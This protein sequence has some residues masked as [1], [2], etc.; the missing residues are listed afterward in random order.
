MSSLL[1][2]AAEFK[3]DNT[4]ISPNTTSGNK[5]RTS[6]LNKA[7]RSAIASSSPTSSLNSSGFIPEYDSNTSNKTPVQLTH[8]SIDQYQKQTDAHTAHITKLLDS[9][10]KLNA[11]N[12]AHGLA[13]YT[14][15]SKKPIRTY[16][17]V[18]P[19]INNQPIAPVDPVSVEP[20][21]LLPSPGVAI[22]HSQGNTAPI[23]Y[24]PSNG[25]SLG[26]HYLNQGSPYTQIQNQ[27]AT[28]KSSTTDD[29]LIEKINYMIHL[30]EEQRME[31]TSNVMEEFVLYT[32]LG[33]FV[34]YIVDS[35]S[36]T[37]KYT[38]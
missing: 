34:I 30:L 25:Y 12:A 38:R 33:V 19:Y 13:D 21:P 14:P 28:R 2:T 18:N 31:K 26:N 5:K 9:T 23:G 37:G 16:A 4:S 32:L 17:G 22:N 24:A 10:T 11:D 36:R 15:I 3:S 29:K 20:H 35:F 8:Q 27:L 7:V 6:T 1:T